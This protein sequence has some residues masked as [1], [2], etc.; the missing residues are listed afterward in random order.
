MTSVF[1]PPMASSDTPWARA[2]AGVSPSACPCRYVLDDSRAEMTALATSTIRML[3][4]AADALGQASALEWDG[5]AGARFHTDVRAALS[6]AGA[7]ESR[8]TTTLT[9]IDGPGAV[10]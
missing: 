7:A 3:R 1:V 5:E 6:L 2:T 8:A 9:T 10:T 4:R